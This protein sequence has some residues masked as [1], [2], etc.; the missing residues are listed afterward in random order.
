M[1]IKPVETIFDP[2]F[3]CFDKYNDFIFF[4]NI[5]VF[6]LHGYHSAT[7]YTNLGITTSSAK[8][9]QYGSY[10]TRLLTYNQMST[11]IPQPR[12]SLARAGLFFTGNHPMV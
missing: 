3:Q 2:T 5:I 1:Q 7:I 11:A 12:E 6:Q 4:S 8:Y 10:T 9:P